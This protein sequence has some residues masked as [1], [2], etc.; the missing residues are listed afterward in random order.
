MY[1]VFMILFLKDTVIGGPSG[2]SNWHISF[3]IASPG[4]FS[5]SVQ[6]AIETGLIS[7]KARRE[8]VQTLHT[9]CLQHSRYMHNDN[10]YYTLTH[11]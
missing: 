4:C 11:N 1:V 8:I 7:S 2:G 5:G 9:L 3:E 10:Y 6:R